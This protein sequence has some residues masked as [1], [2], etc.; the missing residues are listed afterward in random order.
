MIFFRRIGPEANIA[1]SKTMT[2]Q[3]GAIRSGMS[4]GAFTRRSTYEVVNYR[5]Y[6]RRWIPCPEFVVEVTAGSL[7]VH[8]RQMH[9]TK[10]E[11]D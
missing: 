1:K 4:V 3:P 9:G 10:P 8:I 5:N 7:T 11:I 6:M 2:C